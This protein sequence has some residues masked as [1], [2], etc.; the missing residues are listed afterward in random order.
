MS[1]RSI[2]N[3]GS[4]YQRKQDGRWVASL[5]LGGGRRVTRY[6]P[7][8]KAA[9]EA[10]QAILREHHL[11]TLT[12]PTH[13][14]L[15][16]WVDRWLELVSPNLRPSTVW[17]YRTA[18]R[19][20][21]A[22]LGHQRLDRLTPLALAGAFV[23]LQ[24]QGKGTRATLHTYTYLHACIG[25]A[26]ALG[27]LGTNPLAR[28]PR[29]RHT[30][31]PQRYWTADEARRFLGLAQDTGHRY[32]PL[33]VFLLGAGCR[34]GEALAVR[35][36]DVNWDERTV[37]VTKG[38]VYVDGQPHVHGPKTAAGVRMIT[39]PPF[40]LD[41]LRGLPRPVADAPI[42]RTATGTAPTRHNLL[43]AFKALCAQAG[44]PTMPVH[45]LRH[46]HAALAL[47]AG[48]DIQTLR[49]RLGHARASVTLDVYAYAVS[50]DQ[51][52]AD[53]LQAALG[54]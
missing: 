19:P 20:I 53:A 4:I 2:P 16:A 6:A 29:P 35:W 46:A 51:Q 41:V 5:R 38:L 21:V 34:L 52:A 37:R 13:T 9:E 40:V 11:G 26:V 28:V 3:L 24:R 39:L 43:R 18:L 50:S 36:A 31:K 17:T 27:L 45:G 44:V 12:L 1:A 30:P 15:A 23:A 25:R 8:R 14:T 10:L 42:F 33:F 49:R 47:A 54:T 7:S 32:A 48:T 22:E